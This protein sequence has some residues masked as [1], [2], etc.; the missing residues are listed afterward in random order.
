MAVR[1]TKAR[2]LT[3]EPAADLYRTTEGWVV[4]VELAGVR[5]GDIRVELR[6]DQVV[7]SGVRRD[8]LVADGW[9]QYSMEISYSRFERMFKFPCDLSEAAVSTECRDG[10]LLVHLDCKRR[11]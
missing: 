4:K 2:Q 9:S 6:D 10:M 7:I 3:W 5:L 11:M 1:L 8:W